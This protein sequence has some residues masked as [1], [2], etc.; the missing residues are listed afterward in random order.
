MVE[1]SDYTLPKTHD[2]FQSKEY[3]ASFFETSKQNDGQFEWY[4]T[5]EDLEPMLKQ[6]VKTDSRVLLPGCG[7]SML[8]EKLATEMKLTNVISIDFEPQV[9]D[10]MNARGVAGVKYMVQDMTAMTDFANESFDFV[11]DKGTYDAICCDK[12]KETK[13]MCNKYLDETM[14]VLPKDGAYLCVSLLQEFVL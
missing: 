12:K 2:E 10:R 3:W 5:Y 13:T 6:K 11:L 8:S 1:K 7:D 9:V 14:R 4:A